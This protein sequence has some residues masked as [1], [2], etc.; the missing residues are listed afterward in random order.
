MRLLGPLSPLPGLLA[1]LAIAGTS[2]AGSEGH[3]G[4]RLNELQ[5]IGTHNSYHRET[6]EREQDAYDA[7]ISRPATTTRRACSS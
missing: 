6:S 3:T 1:V 2:A 7:L 4:L 5:V